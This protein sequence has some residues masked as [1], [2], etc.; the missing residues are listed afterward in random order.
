MTAADA[1]ASLREL[2]ARHGFQ[3]VGVTSAA[4]LAEALTHLEAWSAAG[5]GAEM[6]YL[7]RNPPERADP[8][9]LLPTV[10]SVVSVAVDYRVEA[11][12]FEPEA[13][14]GRVARYAWG[15]DYHDVVLPR[16]RALG[17]ALVESVDGATKARAACDHSP[18]LERAVAARAVCGAACRSG[19]V[20]RRRGRSH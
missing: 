17:D 14:Y 9:T 15:R 5:H 1:H 16:L 20:A 12:D 10:R 3:I 7:V 13:R 18:I 2:A 6:G 8:R 19:P 4:P 11:P